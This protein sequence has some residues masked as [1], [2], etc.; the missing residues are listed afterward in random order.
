MEHPSNQFLFVYGT[1]RSD[2]PEHRF[3][4]PLSLSRSIAQVSGMLY[5]LEE[6]YPLLVVPPSSILRSASRDW[7]NDWTQAMG[8]IKTIKSNHKSPVVKGELIEVPLSPNALSKPDQWEGFSV[9][10]PSVYQRAIIPAIREDGVVVPAWAYAST[11]IPSTAK[12]L[13]NGFWDRPEKL[14]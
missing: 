11:Q 6:G 3:H 4:S 1:L 2:Q 10:R 14:K 7:L 13:S 5:E 9:D 12:T 8:A